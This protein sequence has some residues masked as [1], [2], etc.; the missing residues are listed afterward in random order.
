MA[1]PPHWQRQWT[2]LVLAGLFTHALRAAARPTETRPGAH[3]PEKAYRMRISIT[4]NTGSQTAI[5]TRIIDTYLPHIGAYG[6]AVY[7]VIQR[8]LTHH[9]YP[10]PPSYATI[11]RTLGM[12]PTTVRRHVHKLKALHLLPPRLRFP[13]EGAGEAARAEKDQVPR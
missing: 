10:S 12:E 6:L 4:R 7:V 9:P 3:R 1:L 13:E 11:A 5:D 2:H 8:H